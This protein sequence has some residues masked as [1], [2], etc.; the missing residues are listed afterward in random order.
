MAFEALDQIGMT[1]LFSD[2]GKRMNLPQGVFYWSGRAKKES[3]INATI[4][5]AA[6]FDSEI[7]LGDGD[8]FI[9]FHLPMIGN[10][11]PGLNSEQIFPYAPIAGL[12]ELR[13][14]WKQWILRKCGAAADGLEPLLTLPQVLPGITGA[15]TY[16]L[17]LFVNPGEAVV[18]PEKRWG[19]YDNTVIRRLN[20]RFQEF[21][22]FV[23]DEFNVEGMVGSI[24]EVWKTQNRAVV[25]LN[26]PNNPTGYQPT[27]RINEEILNGLLDLVNKHDK[28]V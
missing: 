4:G 13:K 3:K 15:L 23:K 9:T 11:V 14:A 27:A 24:Q 16:T 8:K 22:L 10:E 28:K 17:E 1:D 19:N 25:V 18:S 6:G 7:G 21:P 20:A 5:S 12:P 2:L 26:F